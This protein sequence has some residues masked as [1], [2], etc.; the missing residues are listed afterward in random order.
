MSFKKEAMKRKVTGA[1]EKVNDGIKKAAHWAV[2]NPAQAI[3]VVSAVAGGSYKVARIITRNREIRHEKWVTDCRM[4][5]R[6]H[7][8]YVVSK[9]K[10]TNDEALYVQRK[11][12]EGQSKRQSL[13]DLGLIKK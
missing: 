9:R 13:I 6:K 4:Y 2:E 3:T 7:D 10:L 12:E 11:Y 1:V 8:E 5:D